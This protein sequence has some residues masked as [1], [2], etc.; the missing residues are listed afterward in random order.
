MQRMTL[1]TEQSAAEVYVILRVF[2]LGQ[3]DMG[4]RVYLDP[5]SLRLD[6]K[7]DF[8]AESYTIVPSKPSGV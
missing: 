7:L 4:L 2:N 6:K 3:K 8:T 1:A 5:E